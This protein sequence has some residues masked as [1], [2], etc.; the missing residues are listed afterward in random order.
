MGKWLPDDLMGRTTDRRKIIDISIHG[1]GT[2][3][4]VALEVR[5]VRRGTVIIGQGLSH[6]L[7]HDLDLRRI[8]RLGPVGIK[9]RKGWLG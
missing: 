2:R 5:I 1:R 4:L 7:V 3:E 6:I 9:E 8:H